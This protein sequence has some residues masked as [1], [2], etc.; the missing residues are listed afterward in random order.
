MNL[1]TAWLQMKLKIDEKNPEEIWLF[2]L[3]VLSRLCLVFY[4]A[5]GMPEN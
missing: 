5:G 1:M 4:F 3:V 2:L